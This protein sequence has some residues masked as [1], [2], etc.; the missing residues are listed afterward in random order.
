MKGQKERVQTTYHFIDRMSRLS[1][2]LGSLQYG[3][4]AYRFHRAQQG[5]RKMFPYKNIA[6]TAK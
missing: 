2:G 3:Q 1:K 5:I 4:G 6:N